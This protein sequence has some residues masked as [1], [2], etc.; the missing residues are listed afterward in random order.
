MEYPV[1]GG[2]GGTR[3]RLVE[4]SAGTPGVQNYLVAG[5]VVTTLDTVGM[6]HYDLAVCAS[7][8]VPSSSK[9]EKGPAT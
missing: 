4:V 8:I 6:T 3:E 9:E 2:P 1:G 5:S 7:R